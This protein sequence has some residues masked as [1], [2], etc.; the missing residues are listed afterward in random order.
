MIRAIDQR[1]NRFAWDALTK[2]RQRAAGKGKIARNRLK[3][4][5]GIACALAYTHHCI[6]LRNLHPS[7][8]VPADF[9]PS[10]APRES[11][12]YS[13]PTP[14]TL[15]PAAPEAT[16]WSPSLVGFSLYI[17]TRPPLIADFSL[18]L[19]CLYLLVITYSRL[20]ALTQNY[21]IENLVLSRYLLQVLNEKEYF[22]YVLMKEC[23][24]FR[25]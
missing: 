21:L 7:P 9:P 11:R 13:D 3:I 2:R 1:D 17:Y 15:P 22:L 18:S 24:S 8:I 20:L 14:F 25:Y 10:A 4:P 23:T 19:S 12:N 6:I 5:F 16:R